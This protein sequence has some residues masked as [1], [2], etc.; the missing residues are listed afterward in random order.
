MNTEND[1]DDFRGARVDQRWNPHAV[2]C[3]IPSVKD[4]SGSN[5]LR[6]S[7]RSHGTIVHTPSTSCSTLFAPVNFNAIQE[8]IFATSVVRSLCVWL[9]MSNDVN[10]TISSA[11]YAQLS[12]GVVRKTRPVDFEIVQVQ[13]DELTD[14]NAIT[15]GVSIGAPLLSS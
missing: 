5:V 7:G 11:T 8:P 14:S 1:D 6:T 3:I 9:V 10:A 2:R 4:L 12:H 13:D 15:S